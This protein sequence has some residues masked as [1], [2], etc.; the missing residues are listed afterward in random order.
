MVD[1]AGERSRLDAQGL[2]IIRR[3]EWA[4][5][6]AYTSP[7]AVTTPADWLFLHISVHGEPHIT[8]ASTPAA[9]AAALRKIEAIGQARFGIG[10]SYN[11]FAAPS[12]RLYEGQ[13][14]TRRGAHT[15]H[16]RRIPGPN[17]AFPTTPWPY[18]LNY[19]ARALAI[20]QEEADDVTGAQLDAAARWGA[21]LIRAGEAAPTARWYG[22]RDVTNKACP[23]ITAYTLIP[24]LQQLTDVYVTEGLTE[25]V[26]PAEMDAIADRVVARLVGPSQAAAI[27]P[28]SGWEHWQSTEGAAASIISMRGLWNEVNKV[29]DRV[30]PLVTTDGNLTRAA[31]DAARVE[32]VGKLDQV[33]DELAAMRSEVA[34]GVTIEVGTDVGLTDA[35]L[36]EIREA[37]RALIHASLTGGSTALETP[38]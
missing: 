30:A 22:H 27:P 29:D 31:V 34:E 10:C 1:I 7:R 28:G 25:M 13:P 9:E 24:Q 2:T 19:R 15:V 33:L 18:S 3:E 12:G 16:D 32:L 37:T 23:G 5:Q 20:P 4:A 11:A 6:Q 38:A 17:P 8:P 35:T 21:A 36:A 26:T 14:L